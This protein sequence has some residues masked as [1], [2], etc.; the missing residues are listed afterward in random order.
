MSIFNFVLIFGHNG[1][2]KYHTMQQWRKKV[3]RPIHKITEKIATFR[4]S[5]LQAIY[6]NCTWCTDK[7]SPAASAPPHPMIWV[8]RWH[9][10]AH[11]KVKASEQNQYHIGIRYMAVWLPSFTFCHSYWKF[12]DH[13]PIFLVREVEIQ[14]GYIITEIHNFMWLAKVDIRIHH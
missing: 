8:T 1:V 10:L 7:A 4:S 5:Y 6:S 13:Y 9:A 12:M 14:P 11:K 3:L 2:K